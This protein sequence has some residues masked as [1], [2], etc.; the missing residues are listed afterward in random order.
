MLGNRIAEL[1]KKKGLTQ[2]DLA[3][4]LQIS[5]QAYSSYE[6]GKYEMDIKTLCLLSDFY[7]VTA[8]YLIGRQEAMPSFLNED[9]R[10]VIAQYKALDDRAKKT[11]KNCLAFEYSQ[12]PQAEGI[13]KTAI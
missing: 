4:Y 6:T 2:I 9:E 3:A 5:R 1:R 13:K 8:D 11:V 12:I 10:A 7:D